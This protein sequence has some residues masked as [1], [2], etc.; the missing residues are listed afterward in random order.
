[1]FIKRGSAKEIMAHSKN[2][3]V[4]MQPIDGKEHSVP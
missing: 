4:S 2:G 1:M 3:I